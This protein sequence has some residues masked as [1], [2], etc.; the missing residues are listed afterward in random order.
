AHRLRDLLDRSVALC[1][2]FQAAGGIR[3]RNVT[4]VQTCALPIFDLADKQIDAF[5]QDLSKNIFGKTVLKP[6]NL[7]R[8]KSVLSTMKKATRSEERR[9]GK[10]WSGRGESGS[11][12]EADER[13]RRGGVSENKSWTR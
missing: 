13:V 1:V 9:V 12:Y 4:G 2:C 6:D 11:R 10:E 7:D 3:D 8:F 5:K